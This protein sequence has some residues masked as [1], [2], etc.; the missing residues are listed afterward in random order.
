M[1]AP[2]SDSIETGFASLELAVTV[3]DEEAE[4]SEEKDVAAAA[5]R[6]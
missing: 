5:A 4:D 2:K 1:S 6:C 3:D